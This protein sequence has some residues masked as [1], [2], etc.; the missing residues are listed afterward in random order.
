M[1]LYYAPGLCSLSP[2]II[3]HELGIPV[4]LIKVDTDK[5]TL[6]DGSDYLAINPHGYVPLLELD[7]GQR[8]TE[9]PAIVQLLADL[10]PEAN[11]APANGT[12]SRYRLQEWLGFINSELHKTYSSLFDPTLSAELKAAGR[13]KIGKRLDWVSMEIGSEPYLMGEQF[14]VADAYLFTVLEWSRF[15]AI[16]LEN[17]PNLKVHSDRMRQRPAVRAALRAEGLLK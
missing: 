7:D 13:A 8:M 11:L 5:H 14:T 12:M 9:G 4:E 17:W 2:H 3:F 10:K 6:D 16:E 15:V 1:K